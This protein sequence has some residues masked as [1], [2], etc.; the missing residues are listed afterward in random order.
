[1]RRTRHRDWGPVSNATKQAIG[2]GGVNSLPVDD[3]SQGI[4]ESVALVEKLERGGS[5]C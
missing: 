1:M 5:G 4:P 2:S 3:K